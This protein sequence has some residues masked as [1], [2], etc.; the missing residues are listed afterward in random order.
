MDKIDS[1]KQCEAIRAEIKQIEKDISDLSRKAWAFTTDA[2]VG[3]SLEEPYQPHNI[4]ISGYAPAPEDAREIQARKNKL[5]KFRLK[6][7]REQNA[8]E[9]F[10]QTIP[11]SADRVILRGYYIDGKQWK[12][13]AADLTESTGRDYSEDAVKKRAQRFF[14]KL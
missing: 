13:V 9:D 4:A 6:L 8:A 11:N 5:G 10:L 1:L 7:L 14:K 2:V 3:S 12:D